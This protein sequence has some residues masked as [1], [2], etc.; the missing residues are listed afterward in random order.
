M[1]KVLDSEWQ[2]ITDCLKGEV[3][4]ISFNT[5]IS[6]IV[7][8]FIED[9]VIYL[10]V[11]TDFHRTNIQSRFNELLK[12]TIKFVKNSDFEIRYLL[13]EEAKKFEEKK[14]PVMPT[15]STT[16]TGL[17]PRY[18]FENLSVYSQSNYFK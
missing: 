4:E 18:I 2:K 12:N 13:P 5:W 16:A 15:Y 1:A 11:P 14:V 6:P 3:T 17:N 9:N 8:L 10:E 7:P